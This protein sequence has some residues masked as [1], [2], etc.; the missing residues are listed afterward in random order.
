MFL[1]AEVLI[2]IGPIDASSIVHVQLE[3]LECIASRCINPKMHWIWGINQR[4]VCSSSVE[5][6]APPVTN[7]KLHDERD[8]RW[9]QLASAEK[10]YCGER[11][12]QRTMRGKR[13]PVKEQPIERKSARP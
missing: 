8:R 1:V 13:N 11:T 3:S 12:F 9:L 7:T 10:Q 6:V 2:K 4:I 5:A